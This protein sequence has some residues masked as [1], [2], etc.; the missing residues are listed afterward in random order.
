ME[1]KLIFN[2]P[3]RCIINT[4]IAKKTILE[5]S[6]LKSFEKK[7]IRE[8]VQDIFWV[9]G[10]KPTNINIPALVNGMVSF[11][12]VHFIRLQLKNQTKLKK[13]C[14]L[15]QNAIPYPLVLLVEHEN[16]F[17]FN[18]AHKRINQNDKQ[19]RTIEGFNYTTWLN[20]DNKLTEQFL[21]SLKIEKLNANNLRTLYE[22]IT[23]RIIYLNSAEISGEFVVKDSTKAK[24]NV[25]VLNRIRAIDDEI[26]SLKNKIKNESQF[27]A[28]VDMNMAIKKLEEEKKTISKE[29]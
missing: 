21:D 6:E 15:L 25:E 4:R 3:D 22:S 20:N 1:I 8:D 16:S 26:T 13:A 9:A 28:K 24:Q 18:V 12:E 14:E 17:C 2:I 11:D 10:I 7:I 29:L 23:E 27:S 5:N 19:K